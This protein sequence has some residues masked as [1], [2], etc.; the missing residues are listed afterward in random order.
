VTR[1]ALIAGQGALPH[2]IAR[3]LS[4]T[5]WFACHLEGNLPEGVGQSRGF[6][7]ETLGTLLEDLGSRDVDR[8]VFAG[9]IG[10]PV[11]D[12]ARL[13]AATAPLAPRLAE[14][15]RAGDDGA[16]RAV[17]DIFETAGLTVVAPQDLDPTLT[18]LPLTGT[19][20][21]RDLAD[22]ERAA[23]VHAALAPLDVGQGVVV[24][25]GQVLGIEALPGTDWMLTSLAKGPPPPPRGA[26]GGGL[27]GGDIFGGAAD[28]LAGGGAPGRALP[29]FP[30]PEG[31]V[32]FKAPKAGQDRRVDLPAIG[33]DTVRR[34][35]AAGLSGIAAEAGGI[36]VLDR[37]DLA[38]QLRATG[39]FLA[40]WSR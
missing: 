8:V 23:A 29:D 6:R 37:D 28:W 14:A 11:L 38:A 13:D 9:A 27:F 12:P 3:A 5:D 1:T 20:S 32:F 39:L 30:R 19:P 34:A 31:G 15:I 16:L 18:D 40:A 24:A 22:I 21:D 7:I 10:R 17:I 35:A 2:R 26:G 36:L 33:P 25:G 4:G